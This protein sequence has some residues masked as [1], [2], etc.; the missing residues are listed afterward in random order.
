MGLAAWDKKV[1]L[2][3]EKIGDLADK[4][5]DNAYNQG[6]VNALDE[7]RIDPFDPNFITVSDVDGKET[8]RSFSRCVTKTIESIQDFEP[9]NAAK[10]YEDLALA[11][12][13]QAIRVRRLA[14]RVAK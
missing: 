12:E 1:F 14:K 4:L 13:K 2:S 6:W 9:E 7:V 10:Y 5:R 8:R 3:H 11:L